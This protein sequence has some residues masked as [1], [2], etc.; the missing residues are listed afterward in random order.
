MGPAPR[1]AGATSAPTR[2]PRTCRIAPS[3]SIGCAASP[4]P[5]TDQQA[6]VD[7]GRRV[8]VGFGL[9]FRLG[10]RLW[11]GFGF[12]LWRDLGWLGIFV[13]GGI[14][15]IGLLF[16]GVVITASI[17]IAATVTVVPGA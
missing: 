13:L 6:S 2:Q 3:R 11:L 7:R 14:V 15:A 17:V 5:T 4:S 8:C 9:G 12:R 1:S 16:P 10:F